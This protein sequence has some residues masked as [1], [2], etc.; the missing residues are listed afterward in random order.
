M[1]PRYFVDRDTGTLARVTAAPHAAIEQ[2]AA[3]MREVD[4]DEY[5]R[6]RREQDRADRPERTAAQGGEGV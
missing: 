4:A 5:N 6:L 2:M 3:V 1:K